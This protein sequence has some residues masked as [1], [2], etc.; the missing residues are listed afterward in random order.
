MYFDKENLDSALNQMKGMAELQSVPKDEVF[1]SVYSAK[2]AAC[3]SCTALLVKYI[4]SFKA[5][6]LST[7]GVL[8]SLTT[9]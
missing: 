4:L 1:K 8:C 9:G 7:L 3:S 5:L 2:I 6:R